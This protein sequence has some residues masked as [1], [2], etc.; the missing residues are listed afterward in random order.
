MLSSLWPVW[1]DEPA[2]YRIA[3]QSN[4]VE[5]S[6]GP[7]AQPCI[8]E[9]A[10]SLTDA[11]V[12][13]SSVV[14]TRSSFL[15]APQAAAF[16]RLEAVAPAGFED[17]ALERMVREALGSAK[18]WPTGSVYD[19]ELRLLTNLTA[20][21]LAITNLAGLQYATS[22]RSLSVRENSLS[23]FSPISG[24]RSLQ[25]LYANGNQIAETWFFTNLVD[26]TVLDV[27]HNNLRDLSPLARLT[28]LQYLYVDDNVLTHF[29]GLNSLSGLRELFGQNNQV[30]DLSALAGLNQ[31]T[32]LVLGGNQLS[33]LD[34]LAGLL[35]LNH[36]DLGNNPGVTNI[37]ALLLNAADGGLGSND[38]VGLFG[39]TGIPPA[40][41][42]SLKDFGVT[43]YGP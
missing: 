30:V 1:A 39:N 22:L 43:V 17:L 38:E 7:D 19:V 9:Q 12:F 21:S 10:A 3:R 14:T 31:L 41:V 5:L 29:N 20:D 28:Q 37:E 15:S 40:Q 26:L 13:A 16:F 27:G 34:P 4:G 35:A 23:D 32:W 42:Q 8:V 36:L 6:W 2:F 18:L 33:S 11:Y 25:E 24:L